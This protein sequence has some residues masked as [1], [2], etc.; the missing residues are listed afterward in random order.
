MFISRYFRTPPNKRQN[1]LKLSI[2]SPFKC[3]WEQLIQEWCTESQSKKS[4]N[5]QNS[6]EISNLA[7]VQR[8]FVLRNKNKLRDVEQ[9]LAG[10]MQSM[11]IDENCLIPISITLNGRG[12][13][14]KYSIV[15]L[16]NNKDLQTNIRN[17]KQFPKI[18]SLTEP[19]GIDHN[20]TKRKLFRLNHLKMLKRLRRQ[21]VRVKRKKQEYSERKVIIAP[22]RTANLINLQYSKMCELWLPMSPKSVRHQCKKEVFGYLSQ[23]Q[24]MFHEAK[25]SGIG[26]VTSNGIRKLSKLYHGRKSNQV[27]V[28]DPTS[29]IYRWATITIRC[30]Q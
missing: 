9:F 30:D 25:V 3:P 10:R 7:T 22:P 19:I 26:Y 29:L 20:E 14:G 28:R 1:Y 27:L 21:R 5:N 15:C 23:S 18:P 17:R 6:S 12:N 8:F 4:V 24:F 11:D 2:A 16:P 13:I